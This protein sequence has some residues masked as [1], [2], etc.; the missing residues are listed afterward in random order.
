MK[1]SSPKAGLEWSQLGQQD[2]LVSSQLTVA[3]AHFY[4]SGGGRGMKMNSPL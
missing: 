2:T 1:V 3:R 4:D